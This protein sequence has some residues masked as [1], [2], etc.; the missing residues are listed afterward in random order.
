MEYKLCRDRIQAYF[1]MKKKKKC[2]KLRIKNQKY[3]IISFNLF[4]DICTNYFS[5]LYIE[6]SGFFL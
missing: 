4:K 5:T 3:F 1:Y 2:K 6:N